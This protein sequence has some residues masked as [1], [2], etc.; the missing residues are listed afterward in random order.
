MNPSRFATDIGR[1]I[2]QMQPSFSY[3]HTAKYPQPHSR[4]WMKVQTINLL[5]AAPAGNLHIPSSF[6]YVSVLSEYCLPY[7]K[8][9]GN[10]VSY[11]SEKILEEKKNAESA[12][13]IL[14]GKITEQVGF[15]LPDSDL[16]RNLIVVKK[17]EKTPE[18]Y[19][20]KAGT[21][22]KKPL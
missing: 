17:V 11:K 13:E 18:K 12:I 2:P 4:M 20:R 9:G 14:G 16:Y 5:P 21:A 3:G 19:P 15:F 10:F 7:V 6:P 22:T 1:Y 8:V